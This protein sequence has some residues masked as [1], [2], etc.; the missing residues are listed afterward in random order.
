MPM[1]SPILSSS[2]LTISDYNTDLTALQN[3]YYAIYGS[4]AQLNANDVDGQLLAIFAQAYF[5]CTQVL[6]TLYNNFSPL[7]A[8]G[9]FLD[10]IVALNGI[11]R[12]QATF[13]T[14]PV[15]VYGTAGIIIANGIIGDNLGLGTSWNLP[16]SVTIGG[17]GSVAT[18]ATCSI[19]GNI[20]AAIGTLTNIL[21]PTAG[22]NSVT[23]T[24]AATTGLAVE[25]DSQLTQTQQQ[26]LVGSS[27]TFMQ[28]IMGAVLRVTGVSAVNV[29]NNTSN[30]TDGNGVPA[31]SFALIVSG[32]GTDSDIGTAIALSKPPAIGTYGTTSYLY[33]DSNGVPET[34]R[35]Y[36]TTLI[37]IDLTITI[38]PLTGYASA[39]KTAIQEA[40]YNFVN[41]FIPNQDSYISQLTT[42]AGLGATG[43]GLTYTITSVTQALHGNSQS[44]VNLSTLLYQQFFTNLADVTVVD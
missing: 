16:A 12:Q 3:D 31:H 21:T 33:T 6:Q 38:V 26:T 17:G 22:W 8:Q 11:T 19:A 4:D 43:Q 30:S 27:E 23:N 7:T 32:T 40:I 41:S 1:P 42:I 35:W 14:A 25:L 5:D 39:T 2:G 29:D 44:S 15:T 37:R 34:I 9:P 13:S 28:S 18:T 24:S 36:N 10:N 20:A